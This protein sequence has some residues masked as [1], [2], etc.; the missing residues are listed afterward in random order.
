M[1]PVALP[2]FQPSAPLPALR[3]TVFWDLENYRVPKKAEAG[4]VV[5]AL[6]STILKT[7]KAINR[8]APNQSLNTSFAAFLHLQGTGTSIPKQVL[9][10]LQAKN[11]LL[12][13]SASSKPSKLHHK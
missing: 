6:Q 3:V 10:K 9:D 2:Q 4:K 7:L 11:V 8:V 13:F 5:D 12:S 1:V